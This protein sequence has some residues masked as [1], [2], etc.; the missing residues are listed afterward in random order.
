MSAA[1]QRRTWTGFFGYL[2]RFGYFTSSVAER[3]N[4]WIEEAQGENHLHVLV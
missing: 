4:N 1:I 2:L 3:R